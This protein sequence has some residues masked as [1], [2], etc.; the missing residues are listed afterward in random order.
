M[1]RRLTGTARVAALLGMI[2]VQAGVFL[3][4]VAA[5][6]LTF[7]LGLVFLL[8]PQ[9]RMVRA[10]AEETRR[11][12]GAWT[13]VR[14]ASPYLAEPPPPRPEVDGLYRYERTLYKS[15]RVPTWNARWKWM[16]TDPATWR[17][18]LWLGLD[19]LV[20]LALLPLLLAL[21]TRGLGV[22]GQWCALLLSPTRA[23]VLRGQ[24][25]HLHQSRSIAADSQAAEMR[26]I[27]RDLHDGTQARLIAIGMTL[28]AAEELMD[29]DPAAA[30]TLM[31]KARDASAETLT[32]LRRLIRGIHPPVLAE[33]GLADAVRALAMDTALRVEVEVDLPH[34]P[35][36][37]VEAA[38]YFAVSELLA[39]AARHGDARSA[40][41]DISSDG[42]SLRV[43][44]TDDGLGGADPAKG[45]GL[46]GIERRLAAFDGVMAV[47]S[48]PGGPTS[49]M[50]VLPRVLPDHWAGVLP[51]LPRWKAV[52]VALCWSLAWCPLFPQGLVAAALKIF[53]VREKS[54]FLALHVAEPFQWPV[55]YVMVTLGLAM[56]ATAIAIPAKHNR[57]RLMAQAPHRLGLC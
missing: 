55:V 16:T 18:L 40:S 25:S 30:K 53:D 47:N 22:Y 31:S 5:V 17:D 1:L 43:T 24:L 32:E 15:P 57:D 39:N 46:R 45:S 8:P 13:G 28:G 12:I 36:P 9:I 42:P 27:E 14:I 19:P 35:E 10:L 7:T 37:P 50:M 21:P 4:S 52:V 56:Y 44:V 54:W 38:V 2:L 29:A 11:R 49:V 3:L 26:R 33:R 51:K 20:K 34:R 6:T 23:S 48:P 41:V